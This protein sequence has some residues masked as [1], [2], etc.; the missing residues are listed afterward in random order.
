[1]FTLLRLTFSILSNEYAFLPKNKN[2]Y[3]KLM[4]KFFHV[5][6]WLT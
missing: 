6:M 3:Y 5:F 2:V 4:V 1:M